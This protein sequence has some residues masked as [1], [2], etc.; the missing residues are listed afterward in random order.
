VAV[1]LCSENGFFALQAVYCDG[2]HLG[3]RVNPVPFVYKTSVTMD[4]ASSLSL[5]QALYCYGG[6]QGGEWLTLTLTP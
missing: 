5:L 2:G 3:L 6:H 1:R 4:E